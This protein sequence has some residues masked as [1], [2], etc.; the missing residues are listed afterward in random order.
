MAQ[1]SAAEHAVVGHGE[2]DAPL[3]TVDLSGQ[4]ARRSRSCL[5]RRWARGVQGTRR[6]FP[7]LRSAR[8]RLLPTC[9]TATCSCM[10]SAAQLA[11][12]R[13]W[14]HRTVNTHLTGFFS[15]YI[16]YRNQEHARI[17]PSHRSHLHAVWKLHEFYLVIYDRK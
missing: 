9:A 16:I 10:R 8:Q 5:W 1:Q 14:A 6:A 13:C 2:L 11:V 15:F 3:A 7:W 17:V 12:D 4:P